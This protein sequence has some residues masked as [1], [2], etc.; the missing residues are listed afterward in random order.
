MTTKPC[1]NVLTILLISSVLTISACATSNPKESITN[2]TSETGRLTIEKGTPGTPPNPTQ[3]VATS[4]VG[5]PDKTA[6]EAAREAAHPPRTLTSRI[7]PKDT[8]VNVR[9]APS[10]KSRNIAVLKGGQT[11]EILEVRDVWMKVKWQTGDVA[12]QGWLKKR[13]VEGYDQNQ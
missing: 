7:N 10:V 4:Q 6:A 11:V 9:S 13:F 12:K 2:K 1:R 3:P 8:F 5:A